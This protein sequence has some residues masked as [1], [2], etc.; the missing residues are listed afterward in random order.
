[1][2]LDLFIFQ[3]SIDGKS[4]LYIFIVFIAFMYYS[5]LLH[6]KNSFIPVS[7]S[8]T[9]T[10]S[11]DLALG[12]S[13]LAWYSVYSVFPSDFRFYLPL[14]LFQGSGHRTVQP[15]LCTS[16]H[17]LAH[18]PLFS[19]KNKPPSCFCLFLPEL[20]G[21]NDL[22]INWPFCWEGWKVEI[23]NGC[24]FLGLRTNRINNFL[25]KIVLFS[26]QNIVTFVKRWFSHSSAGL[27]S[28]NH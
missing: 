24:S 1:M 11:V 15:D 19:F 27:V 3:S 13:N 16:L 10:S 14:G 26:A 6:G 7:I 28:V 4:V 5:V 21:P 25:Q 18:L 23:V 22:E 9:I 12:A 17:F 20:L 8:V 2:Y